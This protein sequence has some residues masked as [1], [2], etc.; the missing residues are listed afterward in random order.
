MTISLKDW[1]EDEPEQGKLYAGLPVTPGGPPQEEVLL[2]PNIPDRGAEARC[3]R[4]LA[5]GGLTCR[6]V[7][8]WRPRKISTLA[9]MS[10]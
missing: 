7:T 10:R 2:Q 6:S 8:G 3:D 9:S 1:D 4:S 5:E